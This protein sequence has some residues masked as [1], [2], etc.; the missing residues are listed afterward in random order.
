M[1]CD[2]TR[3][4]ATWSGLIWNNIVYPIRGA[5]VETQQAAD[6]ANRKYKIIANEF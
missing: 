1:S 2:V 5:S 4:Q 3:A 6:P